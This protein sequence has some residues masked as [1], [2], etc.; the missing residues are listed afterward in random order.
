V[1]HC[2]LWPALLYFPHYVIN[3]KFLKKFIEYK[4]CFFIFST[5]FVW[6]I[7]RSKNWVRYDKCRLVFMWSTF[8]SCQILTTLESSWQV[9]KK[10]SNTKFH[11][12]LSSH[13]RVVPC[14]QTDMTKKSLFAILQMCLKLQPRKYFNKYFFLSHT[15][16]NMIIFWQPIHVALRFKFKV[17]SLNWRNIL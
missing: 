14:R 1:P 11:V 5:M 15:L 6:H 9:F 12:N 8:Y 7:S 16:M 3:D 17:K 2:H 4:T 13:S 10:Y